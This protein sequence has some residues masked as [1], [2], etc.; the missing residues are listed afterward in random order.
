[1]VVH[2]QPESSSVMN[3]LPFRGK[4]FA[5]AIHQMNF[6]SDSEHCSRGCLSN[7]FEQASVEPIPSAFWQTS[8]RTLD[9]QS[10]ECPDISRGHCPRAL[11]KNLWC[12]EHAP[13]TK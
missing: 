4:F 5:H 1:M 10:R 9:A 3:L 7:H 2:R 6:R 12:T 8:H 11:A 13:S